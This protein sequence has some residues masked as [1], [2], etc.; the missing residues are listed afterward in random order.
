VS[1][2]REQSDPKGID[3]VQA[4]LPGEA[5]PKTN[6]ANG[7]RGALVPLAALVAP[8]IESRPATIE[9]T[10]ARIKSTPGALLDDDTIAFSVL[11]ATQRDQL[12]F[13]RLLAALR[14]AR[15][16]GF[17]DWK[18]VV[19]QRR[20]EAEAKAPRFSE[21]DWHAELRWAEGKVCESIGNLLIVLRNTYAG[22][23]TF[24]E[25]AAVPCLD[26]TPFR[27]SDVTTMRA[28]IEESER[29]EFSESEMLRAIGVIAAENSFH[30]VR[31]Y[32]TGLVWDGVERLDNVA[33]DYLHVNDELSAAMF[34]KWGVACAA[35]ALR[36]GCKLDNCLVLV[37]DEA[38]RKSTFFRVAGGDFF[39]DSK[40]DIT[41]RKG[42]M[43]A[44]SAWIYEWP[45]VDRMLERKHDSDVKAY[46]TQQSDSFVPMFGR[47]VATLQRSWVVCGTTNKEKFVTSATG[48][49]RWW[50]IPVTE[51]IDTDGFALVRDQVWA[52]AVHRFRLY[53]KA[54]KEGIVGDANP[55]RW[56]LNEA[57]ELKRAARNED[58]VVTSPDLEAVDAWLCGE[59]LPCPACKGTGDGYGGHQCATCNGTA[60]IKPP[61]FATDLTSGRRYVVTRDVLS[62]PLGVPPERHEQNATRVANVLRRL[63]W[64]SGKRIRPGG[65][66]GPRVT[67]YYA[68]PSHDEDERQCAAALAAEAKRTK[69]A[70]ADPKASQ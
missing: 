11:L 28:D 47:A 1:N 23:L 22:R 56:W 3:M 16:Q 12:P 43:L 64:R 13:A 68:P 20:R 62:G 39:K 49:R 21:N 27:D 61:D 50:V 55:Y 14:E 29:L 65:K 67:P 10:V 57:G 53:E 17:A 2:E 59:G 6:G 36:P 9:S 66:D 58:H 42:M 4:Q 45:E 26:G 34:S 38:F 35:R 7:K 15:V 18:K 63:G 44:H 48:S 31:D 24:N 33:R 19:G 54:E 46:V 41:D 37:G 25:M 40:V 51:R 5:H 32:L 8:I 70:A 60:R 69:Q 52:E 30:P